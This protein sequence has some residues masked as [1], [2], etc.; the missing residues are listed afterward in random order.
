MRDI[1][2]RWCGLLTG[3]RAC[4]EI[5]LPI[6]VQASRLPARDRQ[7]GRL[8]HNIALVN[9]IL[10]LALTL[11]LS[12]S[13]TL[14]A[15]FVEHLSPPAL[16]R[17]KT[18]RITLVGS[19]LGEATGLWTSLP[20]EVVAASLVEPSQDGQAVLDVKVA[21]NAPLGLYGMR[22]ASRSGLSNVKL[23]L[24]DDLRVVAEREP[25]N[26]AEAPQRLSW[27]VAVLGRAEEADVDRYAIDVEAGQRVT[28]EVVGNRLGQDFD[29]VVTIK[30]A[31]G[32]Q[33]LERDNDIGLMFDCRFAHTFELTGT[34]TIE[35][36][37]TRYRGSDHLF[38]VLRVG[39]FPEGRAALPSTI[40]PGESLS[41]SIP[42]D[43]LFAQ[44]V[45][46]PKTS[47]PASFFQELRR[48]RDQASAWVPI[49][50]SKYS[51]TVEQEP[52][53]DP[54]R[55]TL[56]PIPRVLHGAIASPSDRDDFAF[57]MAAG[58]RI[59]ARVESRALG[60]PADLDVM[61]FDPSGK[62][63][64]RLDTLPDGEA[65]LDIQAK[66]KGRYVLA[67]RSLT[68][69]GGPEYVYRVTIAPREPMV[70]LVSDA[71]SLAIPR[72]SYQPLP[73]SLNRT[74][75][76]GPV[77]LQLRGAPRGMVLRTEVIREGES[78]L[79][80][81][82]LVA[83]GVPEGL[84]SVQVVA[85]IRTDGIERT[86]IATT[87]PLVD[88]LPSG[89]G[90]HGE[91][92][93]LRED[94]RRLP[95]SLTDQ[96]AVLVTPP[97]PYTFELPDRSVIL[98]RYLEATFRLATTR[99]LGFDAPITFVARGGSLEPLNLQKPRIVAKIAPA[100]RESMIVA[101]VLKSGVNSELRKQRVTVTA[102]ANDGGRSVDL[103]RSFELESKVAYKL[104]ADS[105][106][107]EIQAGDSATV[108][109]RV[110]RIPPFHG[111]ITIRTSSD[112]QWSLPPVVNIA[113]GADRA[114]LKVAVPPGT[115]PGIYRIALAGSAR[116][117]K[118]DE[119]VTGKPIEVVV[120]RPKGGRT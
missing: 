55:A 107:L 7:A 79:A 111:P 87:L 60:S 19:E 117:S 116:V 21:P 69:E 82:I 89:R 27:P 47:A 18:N 40:R 118:F 16:M 104:S 24:I 78:E 31:Q 100:T 22:L 110:D 68:G 86:S 54:A 30:D 36:R 6:V 39:G 48:P 35:V 44:Q 95:P 119:P 12:G 33:V 3:L 29:P 13:C 75:F 57:E 77:A 98:P 72:G 70:Q 63:I 1:Q 52:D 59:T 61:L 51:S 37:D 62:T 49:Q 114:E 65:T 73:L 46:I 99:A 34:Y 10:A 101:G 38:Y 64:N 45:A 67:L 120:V 115:R 83:D 103:A 76:G 96:I 15:S 26:R 109:I 41:V 113:E 23:F 53:D 90:P 74:D 88:R 92:F 50:V 80:N 28:F 106:R 14:A 9:L 11:W 93:E 84:Y 2:R 97:A 102:H 58:Q 5:N 32:R 71:S 4:A 42:G 91:P 56:A 81:A 20:P 25:R 108:A 112:V 105:P 43:D 66:A 17:G 85:R 8:H 94:Q